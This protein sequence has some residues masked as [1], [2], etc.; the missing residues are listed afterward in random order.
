MLKEI[1]IAVQSYFKAHRFIMANGLWKW[2]L[3]PGLAYAALLW[4]G[5]RFFGSSANS[6]IEHIT[7]LVGVGDWI[8][9]LEDSWMGFFFTFSAIVLWI[10]LMFL[11]FSLF[12]FV[13]LVIG[14]PL[15]VHLSRR[16]AAI[17][18]GRTFT[19]DRKTLLK[20]V[21]RAVALA[22]RNV[23]WQAVYIV[24][25]LLLALLPL[26]GWATPMLAFFMECHYYGSSMIDHSSERRGL[27][28]T[29]GIAFAGEHKGLTVGNGIVFYLMHAFVGVGWVLAPAYSIVAATLSMYDR[30]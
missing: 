5:M 25:I 4:Y 17:V 16:T 18:E 26:I 12:R 19:I 21:G 10:I 11:Y 8:Q 7:N 23:F 30:K 28:K 2:V 3:I 14:S 20:D 9:R 27:S 29:A 13:W 22:L 6:V 15:Y 24:S 1:V